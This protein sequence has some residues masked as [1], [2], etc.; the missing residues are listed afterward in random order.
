MLY[1]YKASTLELQSKIS[2]PTSYTYLKTV[3]Q[4]GNYAYLGLSN[5][6]SGEIGVYKFDLR[7]ETVAKTITF[8]GSSLSF[9]FASTNYLYLIDWSSNSSLTTVDLST[10]EIIERTTYKFLNLLSVDDEYAYIKYTSSKSGIMELELNTRSILNFNTSHLYL[11]FIWRRS[12]GDLYGMTKTDSYLNL[13]HYDSSLELLETTSLASDVYWFMDQGVIYN[14]YLYVMASQNIL[15]VNLDNYSVLS[16]ITTVENKNPLIAVE[17]AGYGY[18]GSYS[19]PGVIKKVDLEKFTVADTLKLSSTQSIQNVVAYGNYL[20]FE[21]A[22]F[23][24]T[25]VKNATLVK[26]NTQDLTVADSL[27][28]PSLVSD[29][30]SRIGGIAYYLINDII[31]TVDLAN[32]QMK[33]TFYINSTIL[34]YDIFECA[35]DDGARYIYYGTHDGYILKFDTVE[36]YFVAANKI[37][38]TAVHAIRSGVIYGDYGYFVGDYFYIFKVNLQDLSV[39]ATIDGD[40]EYVASYLSLVVGN[41]G[42]FS[43]FSDTVQYDVLEIIDLDA[44]EKVGNTITFGSPLKSAFSYNKMA[45]FGGSGLYGEVYSTRAAVLSETDDG[46]SGLGTGA[47][48]GIIIGAVAF[49]LIIIVVIVI[50]VKRRN[51]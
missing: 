29:L 5:G 8:T 32:F 50:I 25:F 18:F 33:D 7:S 38:S 51:K 40:E 27:S 45:Y 6:S 16:T 13:Y 41:I 49:L 48:I 24:D 22:Y 20:Y 23:R 42:Y 19:S 14:N 47:I 26:I 37:H 3:A 30:V 39:A 11:D 28:L 43:R 15:R 9:S 12:N 34:D 35:I 4:S 31:V 21:V 10:F 17:S 2:I 44:F 36:G 1:K 46:G